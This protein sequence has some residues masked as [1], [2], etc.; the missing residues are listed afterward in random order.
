MLILIMH[1]WYG[2][3]HLLYACDALRACIMYVWKCMGCEDIISPHSLRWDEK[4]RFSFTGMFT[5]FEYLYMHVHGL[6]IHELQVQ[7]TD[8]TWHH[9]AECTWLSDGSGGDSSKALIIP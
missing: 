9:K 6:M 5:M 7:G 3:K 1:Y 2:L 4:S 8:S